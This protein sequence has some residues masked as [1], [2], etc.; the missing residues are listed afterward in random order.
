MFKDNVVHELI[1]TFNIRIVLTQNPRSPLN[2][3]RKEIL[4]YLQIQESGEIR[5]RVL[6]HHSYGI[7]G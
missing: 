5:K 7:V 4:L 2:F 3:E 6:F 1:S